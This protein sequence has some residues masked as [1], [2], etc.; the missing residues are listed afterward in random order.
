M[1]SM[2]PEDIAALTNNR[3]FA[4]FNGEVNVNTETETVESSKLADVTLAFEG[5]EMKKSLEREKS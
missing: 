4:V 1:V 5:G 3:W 2:N